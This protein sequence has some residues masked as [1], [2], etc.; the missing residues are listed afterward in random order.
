MKNPLIFLL[1]FLNLNSFAKNERNGENNNKK[2]TEHNHKSNPY[3]IFDVIALNSPVKDSIARFLIKTPKDFDIDEVNFQVKNAGKIFEK[4][5]NFQKINLIKSS[6][7]K[8]LK[9]DVS[10]LPSGF[11]RLFVKVKDKNRK[12]HHFRSKYRDHTTFVVS[13]SVRVPIPDPKI[14]NSTIAG[15]DSDKDGI[16]DDIQIWMNENLKIYPEDVK[17]AYKQYAIAM[18]LALLSVQ[19]KQ[20]SIEASLQSSK[21]QGC[22]YRIGDINGVPGKTQEEIRKKIDLLFLNTRQR[23]EAEM[24][25]DEYFHG[26]EITILS[27]EEACNF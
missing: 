1:L 2:K 18:Q 22:L 15:I 25:A 4:P 7:G 14:N 5:K 6:L 20:L 9:I 13:R 26:Q 17:T 19:D 8:E 24:K 27:K 10:K 11:Y 12:E 23:I 3:C 16:R 21:A